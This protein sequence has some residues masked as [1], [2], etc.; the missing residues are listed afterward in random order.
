MIRRQNRALQRFGEMLEKRGWPE[1]RNVRLLLDWGQRSWSRPS[2]R[3]YLDKVH[4][5]LWLAPAAT[6]DTACRALSLR[7]QTPRRAGRLSL[8]PQT[9]RSMLDI[10]DRGFFPVF[11][12]SGTTH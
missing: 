8:C 6:S 11:Q 10:R 4:A 7:T 5:P 1:G 2:D 12:F 3:R 9:L